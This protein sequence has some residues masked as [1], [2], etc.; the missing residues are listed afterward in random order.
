MGG[1]LDDLLADQ[2]GELCGP[3]PRALGAEAMDM[4][5][6]DTGSNGQ[7]SE[8][9]G[10]LTSLQLPDGAGNHELMVLLQSLATRASRDSLVE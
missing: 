5:P 6:I 3:R 4:Q 10:S 7:D 9:D 1:T 2:E 8:Q